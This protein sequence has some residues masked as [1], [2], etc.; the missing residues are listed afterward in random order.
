MCG[1][2]VRA[3]QSLCVRVLSLVRGRVCSGVEKLRRRRMCWCAMLWRANEVVELGRD[4]KFFFRDCRNVD[5]GF[6]ESGAFSGRW[7]VDG[8]GL[9]CSAVWRTRFGYRAKIFRIGHRDTIRSR[10]K[11]KKNSSYDRIALVGDLRALDGARVTFTLDISHEDHPCTRA[12]SYMQTSSWASIVASPK[13]TH[14]CVDN[15]YYKLDL[16]KRSIEPKWP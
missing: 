8:E 2:R 3:V 9:V 11:L 5:E 13:F 15:S 16:N 12:R 10:V 14:R 6:A 7:R 4:G 1:V